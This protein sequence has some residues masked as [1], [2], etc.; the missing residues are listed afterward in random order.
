MSTLAEI[1][2]AVETLPESQK[3]ELLV[4][5]AEKLL[6][7]TKVKSAHEPH[8]PEVGPRDFLSRSKAIWGEAPDGQPL[9]AIVSEGRG[10]SQ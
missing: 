5:V 6:D 3:R 7:T 8:K 2:A 9:S 10:G 1:E 4:F